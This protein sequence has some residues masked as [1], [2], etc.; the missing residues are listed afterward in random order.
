MK[1]FIW[2]TVYRKYNGW[3]AFWRLFNKLLSDIRTHFQENFIDVQH[4]VLI[5]RS[6]FIEIICRTIKMAVHYL[7]YHRLGISLQERV[8]QLVSDDVY[9]DQY[10]VKI[11]HTSKHCI[12]HTT[13]ILC[14]KI[15]FKQECNLLT[16]A[17]I[18]SDL[19][20]VKFV[21]IKFSLV[22]GLILCWV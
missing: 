11:K 22:N 17:F 18:K 21:G 2:D 16:T 13:I 10:V 1:F 20:R 12:G 7:A 6:T 15:T 4:G 19:N 9:L 8:I 3:N 14:L 5:Y